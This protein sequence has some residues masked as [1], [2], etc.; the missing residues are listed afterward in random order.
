MGAIYDTL[1]Q[2]PLVLVHFLRN[3]FYMFAPLVSPS[4]VRA[5]CRADG[6]STNA[7]YC[8]CYC[9]GQAFGTDF[10]VQ[11]RRFNFQNL[12][13]PVT[14]D[15]KIH[16]VLTVEDCV[17]CV[18]TRQCVGCHAANFAQ[19]SHKSYHTCSLQVLPEGFSTSRSN[20][21][22]ATRELLPNSHHNT[23]ARVDQRARDFERT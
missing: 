19:F 13:K 21:C 8:A 14:E 7:R 20:G 9:A 15:G 3:R 17:R 11:R 5:F 6:S 12:Y 16:Y 23:S 2:V 18:D 10:V 1:Q 22:A 4:F